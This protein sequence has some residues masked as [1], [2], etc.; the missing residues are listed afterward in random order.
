MVNSMVHMV[1]KN[2]LIIVHDH[3]IIPFC[4][5]S[6]TTHFLQPLDVVCFQPYKHFHAEAIDAVT[7]TGCSDFDKFKF[8]I[9][10]SSIREEIFKKTTVLSVFRH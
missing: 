7:C 5:Q 6:H 2:F 1:Q 3:D 10:L 8:L 4:F 9:P